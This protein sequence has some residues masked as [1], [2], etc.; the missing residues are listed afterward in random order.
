MEQNDT[1]ATLL[2]G[3]PASGRFTT[4]GIVA[5]L[6]LPRGVWVG[7]Y[8]SMA[9]NR[10]ESPTFVFGITDDGHRH[11]DTTGSKKFIITLPD[12]REAHCLADDYSISTSG[13]LTLRNEEGANTLSIAPGGWVSVYIASVLD[14]SPAAMTFLPDPKKVK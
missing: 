10:V 14:G 9:L 12:N 1:R 3:R 8:E 11:Y 7:Y 4:A 13:V 2:A 5:M 6:E